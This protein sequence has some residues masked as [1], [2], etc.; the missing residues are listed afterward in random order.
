MKV[1]AS[2]SRRAGCSDTGADLWGTEGSNPSLSSRESTLSWR[3]RR[4][5]NST[6]SSRLSSTSR[7]R[8]FADSSPGGPGGEWIRTSGFARKICFGFQALPRSTVCLGL[9][10][11][12]GRDRWFESGPL[13]WGVW[14]EADSFCRM[15]G[16][17]RDCRNGATT[18]YGVWSW[19]WTKYRSV[20]SDVM[21]S[22]VPANEDPLP[23]ASREVELEGS[24]L[25]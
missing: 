2:G 1:P 5:T 20:A 14:R 10:A 25:G 3:A 8:W 9:L 6:S 23:V 12:A 4:P 15:R 19:S 7:N 22:A 17:I 21:A 24:E 18:S 11:D 16:R 13:R